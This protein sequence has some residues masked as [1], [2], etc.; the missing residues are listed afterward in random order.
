MS[1]VKWIQI[2]LNEL[3]TIWLNADSSLRKS[4][5]V[6]TQLID[7][8]LRSNPQE[9]GESRPGGHRILFELPLGVFFRVSAD[10][11]EVEVFHVWLIRSHKQP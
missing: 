1:Q 6:A 10:N 7:K 2:A 5:T 3:T 11:K 9:K 8:Q 4:I